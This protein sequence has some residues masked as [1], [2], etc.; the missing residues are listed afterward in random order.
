MNEVDAL[1]IMQMAIWTIIFASGPA[2]VVAMVVG[3]QV[4][5][6]MEKRA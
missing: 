5:L 2:V 4:E 3:A 6:W 1:E